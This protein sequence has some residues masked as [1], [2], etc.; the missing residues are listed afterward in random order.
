MQNS[1]KQSLLFEKEKILSIKP[2]TK[3]ESG[4]T[5]KTL[6]CRSLPEFQKRFSKDSHNNVHIAIPLF[7]DIS[8]KDNKHLIRDPTMDE[9][10]LAVKQ[11]G[12]L[13][14]PGPDGIHV[15]FY[16]KRWRV[17]DKSKFYMIRAFLNHR[18]L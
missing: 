7:K 8:D 16:K 18:D 6:F 15:I 1:S 12:P 4:Q 11:I 5:T 17:T 9:V 14:A 10:W 3:L 2:W 13:K